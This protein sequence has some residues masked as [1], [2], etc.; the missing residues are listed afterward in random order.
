MNMGKR[1]RK[2]LTTLLLA[3][4]CVVS[5]IGLTGCFG[6][7]NAVADDTIRIM[8][9][10]DKPTGWEEVLTEYNENRAKE[11]GIKIKVEWVSGGDYKQK[12]N[13]KMIAGE[14][15]DLIFDAPF[16]RLKDFASEGFYA[17]LAEYFNN[18]KYPGLQE[19]FS[20][21]VV[22]NN[23]FYGVNCAIPIMRA[24]GNGI[25]AIHY[26]KDLAR[27]Y[28]IGTD[29]QIETM[30]E[31]E[32]FLQAIQKNEKNMIPLG[33]SNTR[34]F[35]EMFRV[36]AGDLAKKNI[37]SVSAGGTFYMY[38]KDNQVAAIA[39][40]GDGDE[41]FKNFPEPYN[42][43]FAVKRYETYAEWNKY[44]DPDSLNETD[45]GNKF[46]SERC[47]SI[48]GTLDD[49]ESTINS[50]ANKTP[51]AE[52]GE[53]IYVKAVHDMEKGAIGSGYTANNFLCVPEASQKK[54]MAMKFMDWLFSS[55]ENHDL[56][57]LGLEGVNWQASE[58]GEDDR[59]AYTEGNEYSFPGY[60]MTWNSIYVRL[61]DILPEQVVEYRRY[62]LDEESYIVTPLAGFT[63]DSTPVTTEIAKV[64]NVVSNVTNPLVHGI[65]KN[66]IQ[67]KQ[68]NTAECRKKGLNVIQQEVVKQVNEYLASK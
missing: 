56:F 35:Y 16:L 37:A 63:F 66:P 68:K 39:A 12:L 40:E 22:E 38:I 57:E 24:L 49:T 23:K 7:G 3:A 58:T 2:K 33:V 45:I 36:T 34:G 29:G 31:F 43:D 42:C 51:K 52:L 50:L 4:I 46:D 6:G 17:D 62:E 20:E 54:D 53:F 18:P 5:S 65:L 1:G 67:V 10:G 30:E 60:T 41:A 15:Y 19:A 61:N 25:P 9:M 27:K 26:R 64:N 44:L 8:L 14:E 13:M 59:Y 11:T 55:R 47:A 48:I 28:N 32:Q 21:A